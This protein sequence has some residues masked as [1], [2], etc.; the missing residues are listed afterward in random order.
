MELIFSGKPALLPLPQTL[1]PLLPSLLTR[2]PSDL[3]HKGH[4]HASCPLLP[5]S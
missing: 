5:D 4:S 1:A 2:E 3:V